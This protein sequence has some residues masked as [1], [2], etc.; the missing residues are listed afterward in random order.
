MKIKSNCSVSDWQCQ[1]TFEALILSYRCLY[2]VESIPLN[3]TEITK[4]I[5][6]N[7]DVYGVVFSP[8]LHITKVLTGLKLTVFLQL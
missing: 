8:K 4:A 2:Y 6:V 1:L 3:I 7:T 5:A